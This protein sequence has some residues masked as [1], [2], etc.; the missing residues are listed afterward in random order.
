MVGSGGFEPPTS[1]ASERRSPTELRAYPEYRTCYTRLLKGVKEGPRIARLSTEK[2]G[3]RTLDD[4]VT[5]AHQDAD[6]VPADGLRHR[7]E[8]RRELH[9]R[10]RKLV[11]IQRAGRGLE[12]EIVQVTTLRDADLDEELTVPA[13]AVGR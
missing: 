8:R 12:D 4:N 6:A 7:R 10:Q 5:E 3:E 2:I 9:C 13:S 1:S 11:H